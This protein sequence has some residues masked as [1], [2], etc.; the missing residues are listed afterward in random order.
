[1]AIVPRCPRIP[2]PLL[3]VLRVNNSKA[4]HDASGAEA[5]PSDALPP[6][7]DDTQQ[8]LLDFF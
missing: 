3:R 2:P 7:A 4:C 1:M 8:N 6:V 5:V